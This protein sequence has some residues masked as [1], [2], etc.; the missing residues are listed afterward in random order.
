MRNIMEENSAML[1][2]PRATPT[3][4]PALA[5]VLS[6]ELLEAGDDVVVGTAVFVT[7]LD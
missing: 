1:T 7:G 3:P 5:P 2:T 6:P 4:I